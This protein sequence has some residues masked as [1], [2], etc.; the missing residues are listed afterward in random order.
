MQ[1]TISQYQTINQIVKSN[2]DDLDKE[3]EAVAFLTRKSEDEL[4]NLPLDKIRKTFAECGFSTPSQ[5]LKRFIWVNGK[6]YKGCLDVT[7]LNTGQYI[8]LKNFAKQDFVSNLHNLLAVIYKPIWGKYEHGKV[9]EDMKSAKLNDV[10]GLVFFYSN[11]LEILN[12]TIL[13]CSV[14][15]KQD[16]EEVMKEIESSDL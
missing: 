8:D 14:L 6:L 10:Y 5:R 13:M 12:P 7:D 16:I 15:A 1:I 11:L 3:I 4:L 9:A 2:K